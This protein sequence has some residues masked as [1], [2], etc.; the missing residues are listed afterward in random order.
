MKNLLLIL[1]LIL[2]SFIGKSQVI[3][4]D[5]SY[6]WSEYWT[7]YFSGLQ[8]GTQYKSIGGDTLINTYTYK[9]IYGTSNQTGFPQTYLR[10]DSGYVHNSNEEIYYNFNLQ[11]GDTFI[12]LP[13]A[14]MPYTEIIVD[15]ISTKFLF[16]QMR[17]VIK[18][19]FLN[20]E[21]IEGVGSSTGLL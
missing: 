3:M 11:L 17:K 16:G 13:T 15:S 1:T 14:M 18:F 19:N 20:M 10:E 4:L 5:S 7:C 21:W 6:V 2:S 12:F 9:K 8:G